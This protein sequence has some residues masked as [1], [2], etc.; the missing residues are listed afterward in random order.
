MYTYGRIKSNRLKTK[1]DPTYINWVSNR[2]KTGLVAYFRAKSMAEKLFT[3][4]RLT[5]TVS[6]VKNRSRDAWIL[7]TDKHISGVIS[8]NGCWK[9]PWSSKIRNQPHLGRRSYINA[10][11]WRWTRPWFENLRWFR[12]K[13][14]SRW[15]CS[16]TS[17]LRSLF[18]P[19]SI[20]NRIRQLACQRSKFV[21]PKS[22]KFS[23][24]VHRWSVGSFDDVWMIV[25]RVGT[26]SWATVFR[27][28][29]EKRG[30]TSPSFR[31]RTDL[32]TD[33]HRVWSSFWISLRMPSRKISSI[34]SWTIPLVS[35]R[36]GKDNR[37]KGGWNPCYSCRSPRCRN[38]SPAYRIASSFPRE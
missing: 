17:P 2:S 21:V 10:D 28:S 5:D 29:L 22:H 20:R 33:E 34:S 8:V 9:L 30:L 31:Q 32:R 36:R 4:L 11:V 23:A 15:H 1:N 3:A 13:S 6:K 26:S 7:H 25:Q 19:R 38:I 16:N 27:N 14:N 37:W 12:S 18:V 35:T 24:A